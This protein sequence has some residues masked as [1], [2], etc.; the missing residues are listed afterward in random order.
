MHIA[1]SWQIHQGLGAKSARLAIGRIHLYKL[2]SVIS[3]V[4]ASQ[5]VADHTFFE[6]I[7]QHVLV[8]LQIGDGLFE[9]GILF[10]E[11]LTA[12]QLGRPQ[13]TVLL[14]LLVECRTRD[15]HLA[16]HFLDRRTTLRLLEGKS[17]LLLGVAGFLHGTYS[18]AQLQIAPDSLSASNKIE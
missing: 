14:L 5:I 6:Q 7:L 11:L 17:N 10:F 16:T 18:L 1:I 2:P 15:P 12:T 13:P 9:L 4:F 3:P 8:E